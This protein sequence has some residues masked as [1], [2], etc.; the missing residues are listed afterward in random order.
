MGELTRDQIKIVKPVTI[1][2]VGNVC[3]EAGEKLA[4]WTFTGDE[5]P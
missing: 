2:S 3:L 5:L 1:E 4:Y